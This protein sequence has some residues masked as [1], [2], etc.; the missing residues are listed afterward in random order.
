M[1]RGRGGSRGPASRSCG[2]DTKG[3]CLGEVAAKEG[4][5]ASITGDRAAQELRQQLTRKQWR[6]RQKNKR[7]QNNK[8]KASSRRLLVSSVSDNPPD[9]QGGLT[10]D[11]EAPDRQTPSLRQRLES[12]LD[13]ARFRYINQLL[14]TRSSREAAQLF[15]EDPEALAV[16]HRGFALQAARWPE[17][18]VEHF[19]HYLHHRSL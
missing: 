13:A 9:D 17:R 1:R 4:S 18:P 7:R 6:N 10:S 2:P 14:Y 3:F 12:R 16:Y 5:P 8:F 19:V 11:T 15:Q